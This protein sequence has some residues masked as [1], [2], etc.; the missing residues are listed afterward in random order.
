MPPALRPLPLHLLVIALALGT[1]AAANG[2]FML[3]DPVTW[4]ARIPGVIE[5]GLYNAHFIRDIGLVYCMVGAVF[6][7]GALHRPASLP[8]WGCA[9][10]WLS[11]HA[12]LHIWEVAVGICAPTAL[13]RDF[14]AVT[15]PA[16]L[17]LYLSLWAYRAQR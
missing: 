11:G 6:V 4:Y 9:T 8:L 12:A 3:A 2:V 10:L 5:T 16:L 1:L 14:P 17:G 7:L 15:L 13:L